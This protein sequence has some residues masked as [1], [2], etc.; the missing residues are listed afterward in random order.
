[1]APSTL[2]LRRLL[3]RRVILVLIILGTAFL[4]SRQEE[5][6]KG[7]P[8]PERVPDLSI[9][10]DN[11]VLPEEVR[12]PALRDAADPQ[13]EPDR[14]PTKTPQSVPEPVE[15]GRSQTETGG[16]SKTR[17]IGPAPDATSQQRNSTVIT[18]V[19]I[20]D[21]SGK[22]LYRGKVDL[23]PT[24]ERIERGERFPHRNDGGTFRNLE[25]RLPQ[26]PAGYY[27]EYVVPTD[28]LDGPGP[29]RLVMGQNGEA[30]YT[31]DHYQTFQKIR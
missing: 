1:M 25:R 6:Q 30:Y 13:P 20:R 22:L 28:G 29:Q 5:A 21:T 19:S 9:E 17:E 16:R 23:E 26:K 15:Q 8:V 10:A 11:G 3:G 12:P 4:L 2:D 7:Q 18:N 14:S 31:P 24:L 27:R